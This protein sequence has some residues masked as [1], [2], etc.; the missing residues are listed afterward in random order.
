MNM[1]FNPERSMQ[2]NFEDPRHCADFLP[3][4]YPTA[5]GSDAPPVESSGQ[6]DRI[7]LEFLAAYYLLNC[8]YSRL[9]EVRKQPASPERN[10]AE[11][12]CLQDVER[13]LIIRDALE[14]RCA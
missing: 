5:N 14:D 8:Q 4:F 10:D 2:K 7:V 3:Q 12:K 6:N 13:V 9:L 1:A 11:R